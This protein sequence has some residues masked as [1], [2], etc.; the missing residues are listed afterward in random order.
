MRKKELNKN[1]KKEYEKDWPGLPI[2]YLIISTKQFI[3]FLDEENDLDWQLS[4]DFE[5]RELTFEQKKEYN[6]VKNTIDSLESVPIDNL[7][8]KTIINFKKQLG[9]ALI[10]AF[11]SDFENAKKMVELAQEFIIKRN[12]EQSRFMFLTSCGAS[13]SLALALFIILW[14]FRDYFCLSLGV[15]VFY[16]TLASLIGGLGALLSVILRMGKSNLDYNASK[17]LH[18]LEGSSRVV[19]GMISALIISLCIKTQILLPI[20]TKIESAN[21]AMILGGLVAGA[22]ER[23]APAIIS[24]LDGITNK[25]EK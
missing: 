1:D 8:E 2:K 14:F 15:S 22:S 20:F 16:T 6:Q 19:A 7:D 13:A 12:I 21:I 25:E 10:R 24:K 11:E 5:N 4:D 9:E 3:V 23:F 17:R 18:Y